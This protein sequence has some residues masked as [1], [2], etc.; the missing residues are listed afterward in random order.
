MPDSV[1]IR[2][3]FANDPSPATSGLDVVISITKFPNAG[4]SSKEERR[5]PLRAII[6]ALRD[7]RADAKAALPWLKLASFG[8]QRTVRNSLRHDANVLSIHGVEGDYDGEQITLERARQIIAQ[9]GIA[10]IL[11]TSPSHTPEAPRWRVLC[12]TSEPLPPAERA[13]LLA[14]LNGL[15]VGALSRES[16]TLSQSYYYGAVGDAPH[17]TVIAIDGRPIDLAHELDAQAIGRPEAPKPAPTA[18]TPTPGLRDG[19]ATPYA[20][21][22]LE[23]ECNAICGAPDGGKHHALNKAAYSIGGLVTAGEIDEGYAFSSLAAALS[24]IRARC[25]DYAAAEKTLRQAFED[26]KAA[27]RTVP[28]GTPAFDPSKMGIFQPREASGSSADIPRI[29]EAPTGSSGAATAPTALFPATPFNPRELGDLAPRRW[30]YGHFLIE[31]FLSVLGAPGG[32]GKTAYA[33]S[34]SLSVALGRPLLGEAVHMP[35]NVWLYNLEDPRDE[36]LRR[37]YAG[38]LHHQINPADLEGRLFLDSG[39]D[40]AL[41]VAERTKDGDIVA[42]P[43][44]EPLVAELKARGIRLLVV[45]PF[46]KSHRLE[47]NRNEQIDFAATLWNRV[48]ELANCAILLVHHFRKGGMAGDADAFR[49]ASALVDAARAAVALSVMSEKDADRLG[50][51]PDERRFHIRAD[52]AK[53]N[54][55]PPPSEAVWLRLESVDLPNGD[56]VQAARRWEPPSPWGNLPMKMIVQT[57]DAI[58][59]GRPNG[60]LWSPRKEAKDGWVGRVVVDMTAVTEGQALE[61]VRQWLDT[62]L[63]TVEEFKNADRQMRKGIKVDPAKVQQ[64]RQQVYGSGDASDE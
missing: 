50:L 15:F 62:N 44:V 22:A 54:L 63:L 59:A 55:A 47:E 61:I 30:V 10:A 35:G 33:I 40:R 16:W 46:V 19:T 45:D 18:P 1:G 49:G 14:R 39:R 52:N 53:L 48:A 37:I 32:T 34:V 41:V 42:T 9:A 7:T 13:R 60:D 8:E 5:L 36:I 57:L 25:E 31:R 64:M 28:E 43:L 58:A 4:A 2:P 3:E 56:K 26:G 38:C 21:R 51:E 11:Y 17:H 23:L 29:S 20:R 12:P 24:S 27:R 6:G